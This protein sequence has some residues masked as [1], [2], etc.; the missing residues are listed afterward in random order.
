MPTMTDPGTATWDH[1]VRVLQ[2]A[3]EGCEEPA[4]HEVSY[5]YMPRD[6]VRSWRLREL[7]C[8]TRAAE[9]AAEH[10]LAMTS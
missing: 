6:G 3:V 5:L 9:V 7:V 8:V 1:Q 2:C 4:T 10:G